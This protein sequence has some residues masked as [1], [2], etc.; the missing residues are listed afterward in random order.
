MNRRQG[1]KVLGRFVKFI[2]FF[3]IILCFFGLS[4]SCKKQTTPTP[5]PSPSTSATETPKNDMTNLDPTTVNDDIKNN[6]N[7]AQQKSTQW[8]PDAAIYSASAKITPTLDLQDVIEVY[9]YGSKTQA[10]YWWT[11][12]ISVRS[13][14]Y[15]RAIIPKEDYLGSSLQPIM[16]QY[17]KINYIEAFQ[18]AEKNGG[19]EWREKQK[20]TNYQ[21]TATLTIGNP[22]NYLYW[23]VEYSNS[24]GSDKKTV[25]INAFNGEVVEQS[26]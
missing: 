24:D 14:N 15:V 18:I 6:Y 17:W 9:T 13:K 7:T 22:K 4:L 11:F 5:T 10:A 8:L 23:T 25:Q 26:I 3:A 16:S 12:S 21:I 2:L 19:K 1:L 20:N